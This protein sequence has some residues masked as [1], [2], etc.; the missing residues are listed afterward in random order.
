MSNLRLLF[1]LLLSVNVALAPAQTRKKTTTTAKR[2]V[3]K[4]TQTKKSTTTTAK[5]KITT[6]PAKKQQA[7]QQTLNQLRNQQSQLKKKIQQ[8]EKNLAAVR[9]NVAIGMNNL[10]VINGQIEKQEHTIKGIQTEID[11]LSVQIGRLKAELKQLGKELDAKKQAYARSMLY[12]Y[13]NR[14]TNN[15]LMFIFSADNFSQM[16]RRYHY[17]EEYAKYQRVQGIIIKRKEDQVRQVQQEL[18]KSKSERSQ[19]LSR[20]EVEKGKLLTQQGEHQKTVKQ[21]QNQQKQI[22][23]VVEANKKEVAELDRKIDYFVKLVIE[24]ERKQREEEERRRREAEAREQAR[25]GKSG[26][27]GASKSSSSGQTEVSSSIATS[28][29]SEPM[30]VYKNG[31]EYKL[32]QTF[33]SNRGKL[34]VPI[35][36]AYVVSSHYGSN[37]I[38]GLKGVVVTNRGVNYT[39][40]SATTARSIFDGEVSYIF[41]LGGLYHVLVRHG[42]YISL[43]SNLSSLSVTKGQRVST[44]QTIGNIGRDVSGTYTLHFELRHERE[45]LNPERWVAR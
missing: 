5:K 8:N 24:Q 17:V 44:R 11:S 36:G 10:T 15:K 19:A 27:S 3:A 43:Y 12:L 40:R 13:N 21:L 16:L 42:R 22:Q 2:A 34:P 23:S 33:S 7:P 45:I 37:T 38:Q 28:R 31:K 30:P 41:S 32:G 20:Q 9:K 4:P 26:S 39:S 29:K 35:N 25:K 14:K 1:F 18:L 6:T